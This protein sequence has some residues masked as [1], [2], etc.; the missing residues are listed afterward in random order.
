M[1]KKR[2]GRSFFKYANTFLVL[3]QKDFFGF[4]F[5]KSNLVVAFQNKM[6]YTSLF[7]RNKI[8]LD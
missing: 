7:S 8:K 4:L 6:K 1:E 3:A 5:P 2:G